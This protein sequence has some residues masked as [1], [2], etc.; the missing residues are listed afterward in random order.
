MPFYIGDPEKTENGY[1]VQ[2]GAS[3]D[4][5][6]EDIVYSFELSKDYD[7][8]A[9]ILKKED[10]QIPTAEISKLE[11]GQY[12]MRVKAQNESG[13]VQDAFDYYASKNGKVYGTKCFFVDADGN[14][15]GDLY[16][17]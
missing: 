16:E 7:F 4:F 17:E 5:D 6:F 9:T 1:T 14:I 15:V 8:T 12:F 2:W 11:A 13:Q 3:Y 10:L